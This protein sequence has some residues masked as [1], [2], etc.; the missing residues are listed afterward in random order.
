MNIRRLGL[1][2]FLFVVI[3]PIAM[4][5]G[6]RVD[7]SSVSVVIGQDAPELERFA[8][9]QLCFFLEKLF[10]IRIKP[11]AV[12]PSQARTLFFVGQAAPRS[13]FPSISDQAILLKRARVRNRP[14]FIV[15]GG[16]PRATLWAVYALAEKWGVRFL[17]H[18]DLLPSKSSF[19]LPKSDSVSEP[20]FRVRQWR[21][22][23]EHV[24][25]QISWGMADYRPLI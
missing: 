20:L 2:G 11:V 17:L 5:Q 21:V 23:N 3:S 7:S 22:M 19:Q 6:S 16:S 4:T 9:E 15:A 12:P 8:A 24:V 14:A 13:D 25:S 1:L 18:G 10:N